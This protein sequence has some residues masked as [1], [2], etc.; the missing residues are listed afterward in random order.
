[1]PILSSKGQITI[2]KALRLVHN[3]QRGQ[4]FQIIATA[5]GILLKP[6]PI[7]KETGLGQVVGCLPYHGKT[8]TLDEMVAAVRRG[9][10]KP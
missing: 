7:A 6:A 8:K 9:A 10:R 2:P 4:I 5:D 3:W 1:M